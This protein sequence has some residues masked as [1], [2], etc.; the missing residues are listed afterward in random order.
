MSRYGKDEHN[1]TDTD[2]ILTYYF[3]TCMNTESEYTMSII[4]TTYSTTY[5]IKTDQ[6][7][8]WYR[9]ICYNLLMNI[10]FG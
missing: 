5:S 3:M 8:Y 7:Y 6:I 9:H 1:G 10:L 2:D 4:I